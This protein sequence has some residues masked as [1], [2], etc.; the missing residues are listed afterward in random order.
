M[1]SEIIIPEELKAVLLQLNFPIESFSKKICICGADEIAVIP[2]CNIVHCE[3]A[4]N[5]TTV[6]LKDKNKVTASKT[7]GE[8][9]ALLGNYNF[10]RVH[11]SHLVNMAFIKSFK[12][13]NGCF[14]TLMDDTQ[15]NVS[16]RRKENFLVKLKEM[17]CAVF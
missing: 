3:S 7:L 13:T 9:E 15:I 2:I 17:S 12:R 1:N 14:L 4:S 16:S 10:C 11:N 8:F 6:H 5:Y